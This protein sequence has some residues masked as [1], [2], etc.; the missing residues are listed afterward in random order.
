MFADVNNDMTIGREEIF[1]PVASLFRLI[2]KKKPSKWPMTQSMAF[3]HQSGRATSVELTTWR[4]PVSQE[5][6]MSTVTMLAI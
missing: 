2:L 3:V 6:S 5:W 1:G 4:K